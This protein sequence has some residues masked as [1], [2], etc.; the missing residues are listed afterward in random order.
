MEVDAYVIH[1]KLLLW[2]HGTLILPVVY[3]VFEGLPTR[4]D[5]LS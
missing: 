1:G 3:H 5:L 2:K 4:L